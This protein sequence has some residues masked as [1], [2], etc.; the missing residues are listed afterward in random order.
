MAMPARLLLLSTFAHGLRPPTSRVAPATRRSA[1]PDLASLL[2]AE[3][4]EIEGA[5][6]P[7]GPIAAAIG[8]TGALAPSISGPSARRSERS[9]H[10]LRRVAGATRVGGGRNPCANVDSK[11]RRADM[12]DRSLACAKEPD[13][14]EQRCW[15]NGAAPKDYRTGTG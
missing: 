13:S 1:L 3:G 4:P 15:G 14:V 11:R 10:A 2:L 8:P 5:S 7:V 6:A 9:S 12:S